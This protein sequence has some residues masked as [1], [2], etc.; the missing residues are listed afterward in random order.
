VTDTQPSPSPQALSCWEPRC[1]LH[2]P[3]WGGARLQG[4]PSPGQASRPSKPRCRGRAHTGSIHP[5][6]VHMGDTCYPSSTSH[7]S[8]L[9]ATWGA[10]CSPVRKGG[11]RVTLS[12]GFWDVPVS[13]SIPLPTSPALLWGAT[14]GVPEAVAQDGAIQQP[15]TRHCTPGNHGTRR[16]HREARHRPSVAGRRCRYTRQQGVQEAAA[17][18]AAGDTRRRTSDGGWAGTPTPHRTGGTASTRWRQEERSRASPEWGAK[19]ERSHRNM[20]PRGERGAQ[21]A[22]HHTRFAQATVTGSVPNPVTTGGPRCIHTRGHT[23]RRSDRA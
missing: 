2:N 15:T 7:S 23:H 10:P 8:P 20:R 13:P 3:Q 19:G 11:T 21:C 17:V 22:L 6:R 5:S 4:V 14:G 1:A 9:G 18:G 12:R 16:G